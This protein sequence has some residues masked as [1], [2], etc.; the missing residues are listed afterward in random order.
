MTKVNVSYPDFSSGELSPKMYGRFDLAAYYSGMRRCE[1]FIPQVVGS[2]QYRQG[3]RY[4]AKT[5]GNNP[6][7]LWLFEY[8]DNLSFILEFTDQKVRFYRNGGQVREDAQAITAITQAN[9]AVVTYSGADNYTNGDSIYI[10]GVVGMT[11]VNGREFTVANVNTGAN[12]FELSG[13]DSTGYGAY[14]SGGEV[15]VITEVTTPFLEA[16]L[17]E[18]KFA[19]NNVDL[20]IVHPDYNPRKLTFTSA[21]SWAIALHSPTGLTLSS[22]NYPSAVAFYEQRLVYGGSDNSPQT[23]NF[24]KPADP[25]DF[26]VGTADTDG[27]S[28]TVAGDGNSIQWLRG[29]S[30]FL[31]VGVFGDVLQ[32]TGGIDD[33]ITPTSISIR[34]SNSY[35]VADINPIGKGTQI[36]YVQRNKL[37][38]RSF[39]YDFQTNGYIPVDRNTI[40]DH[41]T[42]TG[43]TQ[44]CFQEG[45]PNVL[46]CAKTN[47][48]LI[49]MTIEDAED[50]SGWHRHSTEG[51]VLSVMTTPRATNYHQLWM[52]VKRGDNHYIE[53]L[54][55]QPDFPQREDYYTGVKATDDQAFANLM[56]EAQKNYVHLDSALTYDGSTAGSD[57]SATLTPAATTGASITFTASASVF[58]STDVGR[59]LWRKSV[60]G[61]ET[62]RA[63]ITAYTSAT[64]VTC[65]ILEDF[66]STTAIPAGEWYLTAG[67]LINI[68]HLEGQTVTV[69][70]DGGQHPQVTVTDGA[71]SLSRQASVVHVGYG[72]TGYI[73]TTDIEGGGTSGP[74]QT[75]KKS[76]AAVGIRFLNTLYA[77]FGTGYYNLRQIN[78]RT[79]AMQMDRPPLLF[80][81][82]QKEIFANN[83]N[84][85]RD[86][87]WQ[88]EKRVIISQ[89]L[90]F[91][92][93][94]Q[95]LIPY[96]DVS[97]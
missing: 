46:W 27:I 49:G 13:V 84:D 39:E 64:Q 7:F 50:I 12:T 55:D 59:E 58:S 67:D 37:I 83:I 53:Y 81:G 79:A 29:T 45:R 22:G 68:D 26:T 8:D 33:V 69:V 11:E 5:A 62:G 44:I 20:Y 15:S 14:S 72:Y 17:Y 63:E 93:N 95:L 16:D 36:F 3:M 38:L 21:T 78:A 82:D 94:I 35:G 52:C 42:D 70:A 75:K 97:N 43:I 87:G 28:Y 54:I 96:I 34:P 57:A 56:Y 91:P 89:N 18:L 88:R 41:I 32:A 48:E 4:V 86:A 61:A 74:V 65:T 80:T 51:A 2:A 73:E 9:P 71:I 6:A 30:R 25:D 31:A 92:C 60:T 76:L 40:A 47:G 19:Q 10:E 66:D 90:P 23:L 85:S 1:N 77:R 24:S